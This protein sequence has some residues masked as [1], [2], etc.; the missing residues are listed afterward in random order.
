[1]DPARKRRMFDLLIKLGYKEIEI[2]FH[3]LADRLTSCVPSLRTTRFR[4]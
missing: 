4:A 3:G 1:M 2:G